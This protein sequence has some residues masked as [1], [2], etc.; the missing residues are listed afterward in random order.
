MAE[1]YSQ[2]ASHKSFGGLVFFEILKDTDEDG[3]INFEEFS[4]RY[5][6]DLLEDTKRVNA[7]QAGI[8]EQA[9]QVRPSCIG[10]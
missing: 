1:F 8:H 10:P 5:N 2:R 3:K 7:Y 4:K 9:N 6:I